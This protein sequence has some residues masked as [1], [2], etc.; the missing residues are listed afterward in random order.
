MIFAHLCLP[1]GSHGAFEYC[2]DA[3]PEGA[4]GL[5]EAFV[6]RPLGQ[7]RSHRRLQHSGGCLIAA[8]WFQ[9]IANLAFHVALL[10]CQQDPPCFLKDLPGSI[11]DKNSSPSGT[12]TFVTHA[13]RR[14]ECVNKDP[15]I[16]H[17]V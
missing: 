8:E 11:Q 2:P 4:D 10:E 12:G 14:E 9:R 5:K 17:S 15:S 6:I 1:R 7:K 13:L 16:Q 3:C